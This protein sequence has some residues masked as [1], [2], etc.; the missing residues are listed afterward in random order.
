MPLVRESD[1][2]G[3]AQDV[4]AQVVDGP[5]QRDRVA[6]RGAH[7]VHLFVRGILDRFL[8]QGR[9]RP[10][11]PQAQQPQTRLHLLPL[12]GAGTA[13]EVDMAPGSSSDTLLLPTFTV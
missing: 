13:E 3:R 5:A 6:P 8:G 7:R 12:A 11:K 9:R 1:S 4:V 2:P 10:Q